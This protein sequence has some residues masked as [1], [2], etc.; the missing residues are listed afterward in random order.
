MSN[1]AYKYRILSCL[2]LCGLL[3]CVYR[4]AEKLPRESAPALSETVEENKE[5]KEAEG[6]GE[7]KETEETADAGYSDAEA[8]AS[9]PD[10]AAAMRDLSGVSLALLIEDKGFLECVRH[11]IG[12][13]EGDS[14]EIIL[15]KMESCESIVL[16]EV[17]YGNEIDSLESLSLLPNLKQ[18]VINIDQWDDSVIT[19]FTPIA[20]LSQLEELYISYDRDEQI[21]LSFLSEMPTITRLYLINCTIEDFSF[22]EKM[23]QLQQLSLYETPIEDLAVLEKLPELMELSL[24]GNENAKNIEAVGTLSQMQNLGLQNCGIRDIGFLSSLTKLRGLNLNGNFVTDLTPLASLN[25][26]E[27]LGLAENEIRDISPLKNLKQLFDLALDGNEIRDIS[28]LAGLS[29]LNQVGLSDNQIE[30]LTPLAGKEELMYVAVFAN[31][32][33]SMEPVWEVP[34]LLY[35]NREVPMRLYM[36]S[37]VS[38]EE[39][40]FI[41]DWLAEHHPEA[42]EFECVDFI[43]GDINDDGRQDCAFVVDSEGFDSYEGDDFPE[44]MPEERR[45]FLL[46]Q[47]S[48][49]SW[50]EQE[51]MP[52]IRGAQSGGTRGDPY[53]GAFMQNGYLMIKEGWGSSSG[54]ERSEI[55]E[56]QNG[57]LSLVKQIS[58]SDYYSDGYDVWVQNELD[59][60]WQSYV[61]AMDGYRMVRVDL[62]DPENLTHKAFPNISLFDMDYDI[63]NDKIE[64]QITSSEALDRVLDA[65]VEDAASAVRESLPY[66]IWQKE[67]YE[68]LLGVTLPDYYYVMPKTQ[69]EADGGAAEWAGDYLYYDDVIWEDGR[70]YH[71]IYLV[72]DDG[73]SGQRRKFLLDDTTGEIREE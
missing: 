47:Q 38:D 44:R 26:L 52:E 12:M 55:Y 18:L 45:M 17:P 46:L 62:A 25:Q 1:D 57:K 58:V 53:H 68:L 50:V 49:G 3:F 15:Q 16:K 2:V 59:G 67:G 13:E 56:Y 41:T 7:A 64:P 20:Q 70:L 30:D 35:T 31:P 69:R 27:R 14:P 24:A 32:I 5:T 63:H 37:G 43:R 21:E 61:I 48:D 19:D 72:M 39:E 66:A 8:I 54:T 11:G 71:R 28:A 65:A 42:E 9:A 34:R 73:R 51:D 22:L 60:T 40:A 23:P 4:Q 29:H 6:A 10:E 33:K 36:D